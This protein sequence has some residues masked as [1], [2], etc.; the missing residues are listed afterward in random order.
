MCSSDL[1]FDRFFRADASRTRK[2]NFGL[3]LSVARELA[4]GLGAALTLA[5]TPG[6]GATF[7]VDLP[8]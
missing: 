2:E 1:V 4:R 7:T 5:D 8:A 3:G 6:G